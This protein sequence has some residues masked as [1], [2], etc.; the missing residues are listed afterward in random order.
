MN[1][2]TNG[3]QIYMHLLP[4]LLSNFLLL[5]AANGAVMNYFAN[6]SIAESD[7]DST[8]RVPKRGEYY[9]D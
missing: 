4:L 7:A 9:D 1:S 8:V 6:T 3:I 5:Q 2:S